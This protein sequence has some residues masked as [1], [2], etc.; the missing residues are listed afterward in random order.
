M[1]IPRQARIVPDRSSHHSGDGR[2]ESSRRIYHREA[3]HFLPE[4]AAYLYRCDLH[5]RELPDRRVAGFELHRLIE[6]RARHGAAVRVV[7]LDDRLQLLAQVAPAA[8]RAL[9]PL[10]LDQA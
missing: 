6:C 3:G 1:S 9:L 7:L 10:L 4:E 8:L 2:T 5:L